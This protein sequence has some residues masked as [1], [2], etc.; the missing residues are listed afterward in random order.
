MLPQ[1]LSDS[2]S[3]G[4][5]DSI[6]RKRSGISLEPAEIRSVVLDFV[7]GRIP[8]YQMAAWLATVACEGMTIEETAAL[9]GAYVTGG[10]RLDLSGIGP[11]VDKHSTGGVGD[12]VTLVVVPVVAACGFT[13]VKMSGRGLG[14]AG[15]TVDKLEC[16]RGLRLDLGVADVRRV[17]REAGMVI[18]GHTPQFVPGDWATY[19]LRDLTGTAASIPLIAASIISKKVAIGATRLV[20]DVK[21]GPGALIPDP[22]AATE[23]AETMVKLAGL[24][25]LSCRAVLTDMSQPLGY[26]VGNALEIKEALHVL[27]G[28][29]VPGLS[30]V[31]DAV[32][33]LMLQSADPDLTPGAAYERV[34]RAIDSGAAR[35]Q[36][37]RWARAQGGDARQ[38][39]ELGR[40][41]SAPNR[42]VITATSSGWV[43]AVDPRAIGT[44]AL[45][46]G[47]GRMVEGAKL[48]HAAGLILRRRVGERV[49]R[50]DPLAELHFTSCD[51]SPA[52]ALTDDAFVVGPDPCSAPRAVQHVL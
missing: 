26:A 34:A 52:I 24:F 3:V 49:T 19:E 6:T 46:L 32:A 22:A 7:A 13:V 41:P 1:V 38:L 37:L 9:T 18:T 25:G 35:D 33:G 50:G 44:A 21:T 15:G 27:E 17:A 51:P 36:L 20:L 40:L 16:V 47:A 12:K 2:A 8:A 23:L 31:C 11:V 43:Q 42:H 29:H 10:V 14:Y 48:D 39:T 4:V 28:G 30:E 45:R 5:V